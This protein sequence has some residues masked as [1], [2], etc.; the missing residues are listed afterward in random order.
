MHPPPHLPLASDVAN[1]RGDE[2]DEPKAC[3]LEKLVTLPGMGRGLGSP[4]L[5]AYLNIQP[6]QDI[7][8]DAF[9]ARLTEVTNEPMLGAGAGHQGAWGIAT[10]LM[11]WTGILQR[12]ANIPLFGKAEALALPDS[13]ISTHLIFMPHWGTESARIVLSWLVDQCNHYLNNP[14]DWL[15][16]NIGNEVMLLSQQC[17][18]FGVRG[19]NTLHFVRAARALGI[20]VHKLPGDL[21]VYGHGARSRWFRSTTSDKTPNLGTLVA[22]DKSLTNTVCTK[23]GFPVADQIVVS[24][25][26]QLLKA[27]SVIGYPVVV[28]PLSE[29]QGRGVFVDINDEAS[30][31]AAFKAAQTYSSLVIVEAYCLGEDFR[32]TVFQGRVVK[33]MHRMPAMVKGDGVNTLGSLISKLQQS[34]YHQQVYRK[35][36]KSRINLDE[37]MHEVIKSQGWGIA[38]IPPKDAEIIL[39][40]KRNISAGGEHALVSLDQI[41][42]DNLQLAC[43]IARTVGLDFAG[44]DIISQNIAL[45]WREVQTIICEVNAQPQLGYRDM[46]ELFERILSE[47]LINGGLIPLYVVLLSPDAQSMTFDQL[48]PL[49]Q[50]YA[51]N[52]MSCASGVSIDEQLVTGQFS[53]SFNAAEA[54]LLHRE[55]TAGLIAM[56]PSDILRYGLPAQHFTFLDVVPNAL[57]ENANEEGEIYSAA[58]AFIHQHLDA[59]ATSKA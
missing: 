4:T 40:K 1:H 14:R 17:R 27:A 5:L 41:H 20:P 46:P 58:L 11:H 55:V 24:T 49:A 30:L 37:E 23:L 6:A 7:Q 18:P 32:F 22:H 59:L 43:R 54:L 21:L 53:N 15:G 2:G 19:T 56:H 9:N 44:I 57:T 38:D 33:V 47:E 25:E 12:M 51:C 39:R 3:S 16:Y 8:L 31:M 35:T 50:K 52:A 26:Q 34:A 48:S 28:K 36:G 13:E 42:P 10:A 29:E 45:S